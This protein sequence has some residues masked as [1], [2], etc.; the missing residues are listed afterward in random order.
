MKDSVYIHFFLN[1]WYLNRKLHKTRKNKKKCVLVLTNAA[2]VAKRHS[3]NNDSTKTSNNSIKTSNNNITNR[4]TNPVR[5]CLH[6]FLL[7]LQL[8]CWFALKLWPL[9]IGQ[10]SAWWWVSRGGTGSQLNSSWCV[11]V[12]VVDLLLRSE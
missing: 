5:Y 7:L 12:C 1:L 3:S 11:C 8:Y 6:C 4:G 10:R 2:T 9:C